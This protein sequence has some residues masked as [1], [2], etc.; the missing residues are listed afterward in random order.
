MTLIIPILAQASRLVYLICALGFWGLLT[1]CTQSRPDQTPPKLVPI[2]DIL[3][4]FEKKP[5]INQGD[6]NQLQ[7]QSAQLKKRADTLK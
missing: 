7:T 5:R 3:Q 4:R 1:S 6:L 2:S